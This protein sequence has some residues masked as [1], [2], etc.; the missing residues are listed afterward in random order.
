MTEQ[1]GSLQELSN[2]F[3]S[4]NLE[5]VGSITDTADILAE[6]SGKN[7]PGVVRPLETAAALAAE[8]TKPTEEARNISL[9]STAVLRQ[10]QPL[11]LN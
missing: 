10:S 3:L 2:K 8:V 7:I 1:Q 9:T 11:F 4:N 5:S 6:I